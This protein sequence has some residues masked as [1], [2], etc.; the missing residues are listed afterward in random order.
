MARSTRESI[1]VAAGELLRCKGYAAVSVK[2]IVTASGA[3]IGSLYHHFPGGKE[4]IVRESLLSAAG[5]YALLIPALLAEHEDLGVGMRH[6]FAQA[7]DDM[8]TTGFANMCPIGSVAG[9][10]ADSHE[11][12][13][14]A[15]AAIFASW[16]DGGT[17][18]FAARGLDDAAA[19]QVTTTV[20]AGLEG[21]F[22]LARAM[23]DVAPIVEMGN[24]L[25]ARWAGVRLTSG[26]PAEL[27]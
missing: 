14:A 27:R 15:T 17:T 2:D 24:V 16:I 1:L 25:G 12:L 6:V 11:S 8:A 9:E 10:I 7:A 5:A 26:A 13:R 22:L 18:Y 4:Q 21:A 3:P 20:V 23:R 19:R